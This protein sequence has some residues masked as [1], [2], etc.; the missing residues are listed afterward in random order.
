MVFRKSKQFANTASTLFVLRNLADLPTDAVAFCRAD[1]TGSG[2]VPRKGSK[3]IA[4]HRINYLISH[5]CRTFLQGRHLE[6]LNEQY[7][8]ILLRNVDAIEA[9][10]DWVSMPDFYALVSDLLTRTS[11]EALAGSKLLELYPNI[12]KDL[13]VFNSHMPWF[14]YLTPRWLMPSAFRARDRLLKGIKEW[15]AYAHQHSDCNKVESEDPD[16]EPYFGTKLMR[17]RQQYA[18]KIKEMT[19]H[20]RASEDLALFFA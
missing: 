6:A 8:R 7:L 4:E 14:L 1:D 17:K 5:N 18:L 20:A 19:A 3:V 16:W 11:I 9:G 2:S 15:H 13:A 10:Q 12:A